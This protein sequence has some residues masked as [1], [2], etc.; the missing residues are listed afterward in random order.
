MPENAFHFIY[1]PLRQAFMRIVYRKKQ[2]HH[3]AVTNNLKI[4]NHWLIMPYNYTKQETRL[5]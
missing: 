2:N 4:K 5:L 1:T 3:Q